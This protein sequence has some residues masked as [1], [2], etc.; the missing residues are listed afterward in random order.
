[1]ITK[2]AK[3]KKNPTNATMRNVRAAIKRFAAVDKHWKL[4]NKN[5]CDLMEFVDELH[6]RVVALEKGKPKV[7]A[8]SESN[9]E[10]RR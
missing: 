10:G 9:S 6:R 1:M 3:R 8:W 4:V 5:V 7:E 2:P